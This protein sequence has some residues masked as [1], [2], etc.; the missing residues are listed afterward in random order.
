M[1]WEFLIIFRPSPFLS[2]H[3]DPF[4]R[5]SG[6][7][8][9]HEGDLS[10]SQVPPPPH[11]Q[12]SRGNRPCYYTIPNANLRHVFFFFLYFNHKMFPGWASQ[13]RFSLAK[14]GYVLHPSI[15]DL[16]KMTIDGGGFGVRQAST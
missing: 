10:V 14:G 13:Q 15:R 9:L 1:W 8:A 6:P 7:T 4:V 16:E 11:T 2:V 3:Q 5:L 12:N